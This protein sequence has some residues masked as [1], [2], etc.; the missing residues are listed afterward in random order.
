MKEEESKYIQEIDAKKFKN[1]NSFCESDLFHT[2]KEDESRRKTFYYYALKLSSKKNKDLSELIKDLKPILKKIQSEEWLKKYDKDL[3]IVIMN[4]FLEKIEIFNTENNFY[5]DIKNI[6][7]IKEIIKIF[8]EHF[9]KKEC[10]KEVYESLKEFYEILL[11]KK[12]YKVANEFQHSI[13]KCLVDY[14]KLLDNIKEKNKFDKDIKIEE[15]NEEKKEINNINNFKNMNNIENHNINKNK[16]ENV[17]PNK[18]IRD[19]LNI[20]NNNKN[21]QDESNNIYNIK[22]FDFNIYEKKPNKLNNININEVNNN[23]NDFNNIIKQKNLSSFLKDSDESYNVE[24][25]DFAEKLLEKNDK[26]KNNM[27]KK[28]DDKEQKIYTNEFEDKNN[29]RIYNNIENPFQKK[30][31]ENQNNNE[32]INSNKSN[33]KKKKSKKGKRKEEKKPNIFIFKPIGINDL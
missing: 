26:N 20:N 9:K 12:K 2:I 14:K 17:I 31:N 19:N 22:N 7:S 30:E 4:N 5:K 6:L 21:N 33:K 10:L 24:G 25:F 18:N 32:K 11:I 16:N 1:F 28:E 29:E 23:N 3:Y 15:K 8:N 27:L 13:E